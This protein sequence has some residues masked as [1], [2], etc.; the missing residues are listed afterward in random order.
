MMNSRF[1]TFILAIFA[2]L[3]FFCQQADGKA[4]PYYRFKNVSNHGSV[5][6]IITT[7]YN[8]VP[9]QNEITAVDVKTYTIE[10]YDKDGDLKI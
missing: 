10:E 9:L 7:S 4:E 1:A 6:S 5:R 8:K 2:G 3:L